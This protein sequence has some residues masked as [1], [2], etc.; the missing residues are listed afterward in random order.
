[1]HASARSSASISSRKCDPD[2]LLVADVA[3][4]KPTIVGYLGQAAGFAWDHRVDDGNIPALLDQTSD[5]IGA[6]GP[7]PPVT[8][9]RVPIN[10]PICC[11]QPRSKSCPVQTL[12]S[13]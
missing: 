10:A 12:V 8:T 13:G 2:R 4:E 3:R 1:M 9:T 11:C 7:A 6:D 5:Q